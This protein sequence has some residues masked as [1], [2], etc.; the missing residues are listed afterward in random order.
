MSARS[1]A[2]LLSKFNSNFHFSIKAKESQVRA[3]VNQRFIESGEK[4]RLKDLLRTK[5]VECGWRDEMK[6]YCR[7]WKKILTIICLP[8]N[9]ITF[10]VEVAKSRENVSAEELIADITPKGRGTIKYLIVY[11][12]TN[13]SRTT[14][15]QVPDKVKQELLQKIKV[16]LTQYAAQQK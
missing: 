12:I 10:F 14:K 2:F 5:L 16:F 4:E 15:A 11:K 9:L 8:K 6:N 3:S 7:G 13:K 1:W